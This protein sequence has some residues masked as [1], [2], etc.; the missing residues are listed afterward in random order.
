[1]AQPHDAARSGG[2]VQEGIRSPSA[3]I[4]CTLKM[5]CSFKSDS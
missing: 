5:Y 2:E 4:D 1:M 3:A